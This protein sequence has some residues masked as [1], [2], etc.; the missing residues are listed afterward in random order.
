MRR[1]IKELIESL[2]INERFAL[3]SINNF[4]IET[5]K[6]FTKKH[7]MPFSIGK[8][9]D[10]ADGHGQKSIKDNIEQYRYRSNRHFMF[11]QTF[12]WLGG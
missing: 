12:V 3:Q 7:S 11:D 10:L 1:R 6:N 9:S 8:N 5:E 2:G 4:R